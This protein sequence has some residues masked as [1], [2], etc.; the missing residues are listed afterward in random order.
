MLVYKSVNNHARTNTYNT[1]Y[2]TQKSAFCFTHHQHFQKKVA[3]SGPWPSILPSWPRLLDLLGK[4]F[5]TFG[6][7]SVVQGITERWNLISP[8]LEKLRNHG[9]WSLQE[10]GTEKKPFETRKKGPQPNARLPKCWEHLWEVL[11]PRCFPEGLSFT[12]EVCRPGIPLFAK[13]MSPAWRW[14]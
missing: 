4:V 12:K 1:S 13:E 7:V 10:T 14:R 11:E 6:G 9:K 5:P 2:M 8:Q 3:A